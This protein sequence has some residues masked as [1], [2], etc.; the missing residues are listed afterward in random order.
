[1]CDMHNSCVI[2]LIYMAW[3]C[4][5]QPWSG[6]RGGERHTSSA[7]RYVESDTWSG[8]EYVEWSEIRGVGYV[9]WRDIREVE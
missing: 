7:V 4:A 5:M 1:M 3:C 2:C 6:I 9:E 8:V